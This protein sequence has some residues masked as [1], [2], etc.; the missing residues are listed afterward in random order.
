MKGFIVLVLVAA[1]ITLLACNV[2]PES[3]Q[4]RHFLEEGQKATLVLDLSVLSEEL[5]D[6]RFECT[7]GI[8][9]LTCV[10]LE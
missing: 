9:A 8:D 2:T 5:R 6:M 10:W 1:L 3:R 7:Q 4:E